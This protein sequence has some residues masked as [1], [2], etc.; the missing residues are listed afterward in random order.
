[1]SSPNPAASSLGSWQCVDTYYT[2]VFPAGETPDPALVSRV[3]SFYPQF[4]PVWMVKEYVTPS[5][6]RINYG[7]HV[8]GRWEP[9]PTVDDVEQG[10]VPLRCERPADFPFNGGVIYEQRPW[11]DPT[12]A[13]GK[14]LNLPDLYRPFDVRL[15]EWMDAA[16]REMARTAGKMKAKVLKALDREVEAEANELAKVK[17]NRRLE[18]IDDR[19]QVMNAFDA[20][21]LA[22]PP[23]APQTYVQAETV[24]EEKT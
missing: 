11:T 5:G 18:L 3:R 7:F 15:W 4:V 23:R 2:C 1:M 16:H 8:I 21:K 14:K 17:E 6:G 20:G 22:S 13:A 19:V 9:M 12:N 24:M 10:R